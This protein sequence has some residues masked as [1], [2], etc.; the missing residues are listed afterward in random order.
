MLAFP[1]GAAEVSRLQGAGKEGKQE[2]AKADRKEDRWDGRRACVER[3][4]IE[5]G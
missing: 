4:Q 3:L 1:L 5:R 2:E